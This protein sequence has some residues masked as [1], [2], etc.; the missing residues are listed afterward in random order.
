MGM[1]PVTEK[2]VRYSDMGGG[3]FNSIKACRDEPS[4]IDLPGDLPLDVLKSFLPDC[5]DAHKSRGFL[6]TGLFTSVDN[7]VFWDGLTEL[8]KVVNTMSPHSLSRC[9]F[10]TILFP[11]DLA[12]V[13][14]VFPE[15]IPSLMLIHSRAFYFIKQYDRYYPHDS[16]HYSDSDSDS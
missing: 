4:V 13:Y 10:D 16:P 3:V 11:Q 9:V 12:N 6:Y 15:E 1:Q 5:I 14:G 2:F 8:D 7:L